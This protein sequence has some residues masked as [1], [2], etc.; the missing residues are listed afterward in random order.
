[1]QLAYLGTRF[2]E[3][4]A[5]VAAH[6]DLA[7][8]PAEPAA[9]P[10]AVAAPATPM[11]AAAD[12]PSVA[13]AD[14]QVAP[15]AEVTVHPGLL[16]RLG[17][18]LG[19][20]AAAIGF[21][22]SAG[23]DPR[24]AMRK[25]YTVGLMQVGTTIADILNYLDTRSAARL[26]VVN[27]VR[28]IVDEAPGRVVFVGES[29]GGN[30][31]VDALA[32]L[33]ATAETDEDDRARTERIG[34]L[35]TFASLTAA[36]RQIRPGGVLPGP[37]PFTPWV[38]V[39]SPDDFPS[40]PIEGTYEELNAGRPQKVAID[41]V[42]RHRPLFPDVHATYLTDPASHLFGYLADELHDRGLLA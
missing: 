9:T 37:T 15:A 20:V 1:V 26:C 14:A 2:D 21:L 42:A 29:L 7:P 13:V 8:A 36:L 11:A 32:N 34:L 4:A 28:E 18:G 41:Y 40:Y 27:L 35:V 31:L 23:F 19:D 12:P 6:P 38:N 3:Q 39:W 24:R 17:V 30:M 25:G 33:R 22:A 10:A 16:D 5:A